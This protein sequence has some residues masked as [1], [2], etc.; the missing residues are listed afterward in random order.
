MGLLDRL[1]PGVSELDEKGIPMWKNPDE[2]WSILLNSEMGILGQIN[3]L[4]DSDD[5]VIIHPSATIGECVR[6]EGPCYI[7]ANAEIRPVSYTHLTLPTN[8]EV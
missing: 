3:R 4:A 6:I 8:R 5:G 7:G 1:F 2:P